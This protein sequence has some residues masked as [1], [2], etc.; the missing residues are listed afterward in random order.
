MPGDI[1]RGQ[2]FGDLTPVHRY[3]CAGEAIARGAAEDSGQVCT[4]AAVR[5][6]CGPISINT[7]QPSCRHGLHAF[8]ELHRLPG[9]PPPI[10]C[11]QRGLRGEDRAGAV[12]NQR[13]GRHGEL[14]PCLRTTRIR[15]A[16]APAARNGRRDWCPA[17]C[18]GFR[19]RLQ[20]G[21]DLFQ[22]LAR[23]RQ[24]RVAAV[25][26]SDRNPRE[27]V[28]DA[29][30]VLGVGEHRHH[31]AALGQTAEQPA[32]FGHQSCPVLEAEHAGHT[33]RR[34][35]AHAV[36]K[37]HVGLDAPRL[38]QPGQ[39]HLDGEQRRLGKRG[40]PQR[41]R[42]TVGVAV[43]SNSTSSSGRG[44]IPSTASAQRCHRVGEYRLGVEQF[45]RHPRILAALPGEQP[46]RLRRVTAL[47]THRT[48]SQPVLGQS[49]QAARGH[50]GPNPRPARPG[51]RNAN[52]PPRR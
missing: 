16:P 17:R 19:H 2:R 8:G 5:I 4:A 11:V 50:P 39:A 15:R 14:E 43:G 21:D 37:H 49:G 29:L 9:M 1:D 33:R 23:T 44:S 10:L 32:A 41:F 18:S 51:A 20:L 24:H 40:V 45:A 7:E 30:H 38:P 52:A 6:G 27:F 13:Q 3:P 35:L 28:G 26:G 34:I 47:A 31:P 46:R 25:V 12:A 48:R 42:C 36:P 22:I